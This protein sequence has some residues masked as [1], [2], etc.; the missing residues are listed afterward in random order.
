MQDARALAIEEDAP[1]GE[2]DEELALA[3]R[4]DPTAFGLLYSRHRL[5]VFRYLRTRTSGEDNA[6]DLTAVTFERAMVAM[7]RYRPT[8]GGFLAWLLRIARNAAIDA[9]RRGLA[10][11]LIADIPD[12]RPA[13]LPEARVLANERRTALAAAVNDLPLVQQEALVLRYA[14]GLTAREIGDVLGK[15][16]QAAQKLLSRALATIRESYR[17]DI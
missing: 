15:S 13:S 7:P 11:P 2:R 10:T 8:G 4:S 16:D 14:A 3:A 5:A 6:A 17:V 9:G 12:E 1:V